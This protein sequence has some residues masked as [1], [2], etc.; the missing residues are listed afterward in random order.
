MAAIQETIM[1][2]V[3]STFLLIV[4]LMAGMIFAAKMPPAGGK[5][6]NDPKAANRR[7]QFIRKSSLCR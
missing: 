6:S 7:L 1:I 2:Y 3:V 5:A 4:L